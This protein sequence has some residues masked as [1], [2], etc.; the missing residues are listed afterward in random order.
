VVVLAV[1]G[2]ISIQFGQFANTLGFAAGLA[3]FLAACAVPRVMLVA[4]P[5]GLLLWLLAAPFATPLLAS[6]IDAQALPYSWNARVEIWSYVCERIFEQP[7]IGHGLDAAR[8]H[9][10]EV[11]VHPHSVSLQIWFELG[12][13]GVL[14]AAVSLV[15]GARELARR[16][17]DNRPAAAAAAGALAAI[18]VVANLSFNLWAEWWLATMFVAAGMVGALRRAT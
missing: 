3:A 12:L 1:S 8:V 2:F 6:A 4:I 15:A 11:P 5:A 10:P 7:W 9:L 14:L 13:V 17:A 16:F 18:G